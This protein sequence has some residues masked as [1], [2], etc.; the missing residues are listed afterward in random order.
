M[1]EIMLLLSASMERFI[2]FFAGA[3]NDRDPRRALAKC[4]PSEKA[5]KDLLERAVVGRVFLRIDIIFMPL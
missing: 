5:R 3:Q 4:L 1:Y 2:R